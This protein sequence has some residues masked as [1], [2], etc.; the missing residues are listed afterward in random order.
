MTIDYDEERR[1]Y[2]LVTIKLPADMKTVGAIAKALSSLPGC[3][4]VRV[5]GTSDGAVIAIPVMPF[6]DEEQNFCPVC[7]QADNCGDCDHTP[8]K[9]THYASCGFFK[10][11]TCSC[12]EISGET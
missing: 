5:S 4:D 9:L 3:D 1:K 8:A 2:V 10:G 7:G 11:G 6:L 12:D